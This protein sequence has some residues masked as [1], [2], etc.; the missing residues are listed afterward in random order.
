MAARTPNLG[1]IGAL[2]ENIRLAARLVTNDMHLSPGGDS[3]EY[4][5][6]TVNI[7]ELLIAINDLENFQSWWR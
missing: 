3:Y 1:R 5:G 2:A 6:S 4:R 7:D